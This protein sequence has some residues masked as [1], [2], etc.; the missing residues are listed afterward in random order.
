MNMRDVLAAGVAL[1]GA[2]AVTFLFFAAMGAVPLG[3]AIVATIIAIVM[4][5]IWVGV[6]YWRQ[7]HRDPTGRTQQYRDRER[8][9]F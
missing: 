3:D 1:C 8:R 6:F 2:F 7:T 9:G 4:G 5:L